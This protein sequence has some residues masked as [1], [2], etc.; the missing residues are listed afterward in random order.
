MVQK[1]HPGEIKAIYKDTVR[2]RIKKPG[3]IGTYSNGFE[4]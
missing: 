3:R 1:P 2:I 4:P